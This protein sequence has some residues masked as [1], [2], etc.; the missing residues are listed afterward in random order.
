[1]EEIDMSGAVC[2]VTGANSGIG[3]ETARALAK[4]NARVVMVC[5][6]EERGAAAQAEIVQESGNNQVD[7]L[8]ADLAE[9]DQIRGLAEAFKERYRRLDILVNNA[10]AFFQERRENSDG[11]E[12]T[13]ALNHL[14]YFLLTNLLLDILKESAPARIINVSS[15]AHKGSKIDFG[16]IQ[17]RR[18]YS[19]FGVYGESKLANILFTRELARR[20]E[21]SDVTVNA[22]HPGFVATNFAKNNGFLARVAMTLVRPFAKSPEEGAATAIYLATS[23]EVT[24]VTGR[25]FANRREVEPSARARDEKSMRRLWEIS[26]EMTHLSGEETVGEAL[27]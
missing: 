5:R 15:D 26:A 8:L 10:G 4:T 11:I 16:D 22:M 2:M 27:P 1:M 21:G 20:L 23:P 14:G 24:G 25:Y 3:K 12:M 13:F 7:L 18:S 6:N 17:N 9:Q 19:G